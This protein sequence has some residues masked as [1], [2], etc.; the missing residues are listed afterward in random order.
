MS[1]A[2]MMLAAAMMMCEAARVNAETAA[3]KAHDEWE[4][5]FGN[6]QIHLHESYV[7]MIGD[8]YD[9]QVFINRV[10]N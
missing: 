5:K 6:G 4:I 7:K 10:I 2:Q 3:M 9:P 8:A 1:D